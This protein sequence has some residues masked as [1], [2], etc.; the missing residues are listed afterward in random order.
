MTAAVVAVPSFQPLPRAVTVAVSFRPA[1][2]PFTV[3]DDE[4]ARGRCLTSDPSGTSTPARTE[5]ASVSE[6]VTLP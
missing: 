6:G 1:Y 3:Y 4:V 2:V 5:L